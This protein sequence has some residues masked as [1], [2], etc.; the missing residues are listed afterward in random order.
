MDELRHPHHLGILPETILQPVLDRLD[1]VVGTR[2]DILDGL[3][4]SD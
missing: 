3:R 1:I 2:L 4:V